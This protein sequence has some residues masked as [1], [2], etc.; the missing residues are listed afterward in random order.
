VINTIRPVDDTDWPAIASI[1]NYFMRHLFA[2]YDDQPVEDSFF[3]ATS[4]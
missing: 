2:A 3:R 1:F 4:S